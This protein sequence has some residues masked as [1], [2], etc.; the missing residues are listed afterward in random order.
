MQDAEHQNPAND[1]GKEDSEAY[2]NDESSFEQ[3]LEHNEDI[4]ALRQQVDELKDKLLRLAAE[5][6][7]SKKRAERDLEESGKYS[8]SGFA[9]DLVSVSEN[10]HRAIENIPDISEHGNELLKNL[11]TG[12]EMT[13]N[14]LAASFERH[15]I[16][17]L[18]PLGEKFNHNFHQAISQSEDATNEPGTVVQVFQ[19]GYAIHERLLKPAMV[20]VSK[21]P[22]GSPEP[23]SEA[24]QLDTE[25]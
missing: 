15:G 11:K 2:S 14:E 1:L 16:R 21:A 5:A 7:N 13:L 24:R 20:V 10:L 8:I 17:R 3:P 12:V 6:E 18:Y 23:S 19:A 25:A 22:A 4:T 9:R